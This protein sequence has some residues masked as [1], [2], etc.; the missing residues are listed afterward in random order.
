MAINC[1]K[2]NTDNPDNSHFCSDCGTQL[3]SSKDIVVTETIEAPKE[4]LTT[5]STFAER[6]RL[7]KN[8]VKAVWE[9]SIEHSIKSSRRKSL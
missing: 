3:A 4:D 1:P 5:G 6:I 2:C 9:R 7:S 8:L